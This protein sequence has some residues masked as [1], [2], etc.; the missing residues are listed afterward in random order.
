[1][2]DSTNLFMKEGHRNFLNMNGLVNSTYYITEERKV[3]RLID[4]LRKTHPIENILGISERRRGFIPLAGNQIIAPDFGIL[5]EI[6]P[7]HDHSTMPG[8]KHCLS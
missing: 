3:P 7:Y 2:P 5:L 6:H 4:I 1:M 8:D